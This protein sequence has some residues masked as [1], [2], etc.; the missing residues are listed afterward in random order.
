M[1]KVKKKK[2]IRKKDI[3]LPQEFSHNFHMTYDNKEGNYVGIPPQWKK[4][5]AKE[6]ERPRPFM[7]PSVVTDIEPGVLMLQAQASG[8]KQTPS[9][10][11]ISI[12]RSNS[13]RQNSVKSKNKTVNGD[14]KGNNSMPLDRSKVTSRS[15]PK[16]TYSAQRKEYYKVKRQQK[17]AQTPQSPTDSKGNLSPTPSVDGSVAASS[18]S[19]NDNIFVSHDEFREALKLVVCNDDPKE[20]LENFVK[21]GEGSTGIVCIARD[22]RSG[23][24]VAVKKMDLH[25]Q[26]RRELLFNEVVT[27]KNYHH[28]NIVELYDAYLVNEELWVVMEYLEGGALTDIVSYT[29]LKE[30]QIAYFCKS[31]LKALEYLHSQGVIHRDIKSDSILM[32]LNGQVKLSDFGFCAQVSNEVPKRKSLVGTPYWMAPEIISRDSYGT[33]VDIWS[34]GIMVMEMIDTE[35][36]FFNEPPLMAMKKLRDL[37][38]PT[39]KQPENVSSKLIS[40]L[41]A[42]LQKDPFRRSSAFEL[43]QHPFLRMSSSTTSISA[44]IREYKQSAC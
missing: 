40:F 24:Q 30:D 31:C 34:F 43:L 38:P 25:K 2:R 42:C 13:L 36:P 44:L 15:L 22:K 19:S 14:S 21:I 23:R 17:E 5:L 27:M 26:Q 4:F 9:G 16:N 37:D 6:F 35:P 18:A 28:S 10:G 32:S 11:R 20:H 39:L 8:T 41:E 3:G 12:A 1:S 33:E 7:D 29:K